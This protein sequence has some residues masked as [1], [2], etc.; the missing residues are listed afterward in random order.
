MNNQPA[1]KIIIIAE[2]ITTST[3]LMILLSPLSRDITTCSTYTR[4]L[5]TLQQADAT[6]SHFDVIFMA[7]PPL[8][9]EQEDIAIQI[10]TT[11]FLQHA[12]PHHTI[13]LESG[14]MPPR[15]SERY[16]GEGDYIM[17][18]P[19]TRKKLQAILAPLHLILPVLNCWEYMLCGREPDGC[20][21]EE[22]GICPAAVDQSGDNIHGGKNAGRVCWASVGTLCG[23]MA[24][25]TFANKIKDCHLCDFYKLVRTEEAGIFESIDSILGRMHYKK[26]K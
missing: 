9:H 11:S 4:G 15:F 19:I 23:G 8:H 17:P 13:I 7:Y 21:V 10:L 25:G 12:S 16:L 18:R 3:S 24:Q 5:A 26:Q 1:P 20:H 22:L 14:S 2:S 6:G